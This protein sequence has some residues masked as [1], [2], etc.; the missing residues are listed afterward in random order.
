MAGW[1]AAQTNPASSLD[2]SYKKLKNVQQV[3]RKVM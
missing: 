1:L 3:K 2:E